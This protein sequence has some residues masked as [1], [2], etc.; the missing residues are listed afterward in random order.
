MAYSTNADVVDE[1]KNLDTT[2]KIT[3]AKIDEWI[4]QADAY[5]DGRVGLIYQIP[6]TGASSLKILKEISIGFVAQRIAYVLETKTTTPK[7]D[8]YIPKNLIKQAE[9][10]LKMIVKRE[11]V[12]SD[13]TEKSTK[14]GVSSYSNENTVNRK[15]DQ[16][17]T[18]W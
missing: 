8:Q 6:V 16:S 3:T 5:I 4:D 13:A 12:L 7:G 11:L 14:A 15:F 2:G 10:R 17:K 18:Q 9:D 1:F